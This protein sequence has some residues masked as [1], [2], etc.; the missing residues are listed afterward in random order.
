MGK[1]NSEVFHPSRYSSKDP[2]STFWILRYKSLLS[3]ISKEKVNPIT[4]Y[5]GNFHCVPGIVK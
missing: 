5:L 4:K 2:A 3:S 1:D